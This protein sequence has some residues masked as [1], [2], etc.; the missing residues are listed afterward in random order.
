METLIIDKFLNASSILEDIFLNF[1]DVLQSLFIEHFSHL[2]AQYLLI[3]VIHGV[4]LL[5]TDAS[6]VVDV[7][8]DVLREGLDL[9]LL[10]VVGYLLHV[11]C[12]FGEEG[13]QED[14]WSEALR[15]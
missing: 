15:C 7:D 3:N 12:F 5:P 14:G 1:L 13:I 8:G 9:F 11:L 10:E 6:V 4:L 2:P